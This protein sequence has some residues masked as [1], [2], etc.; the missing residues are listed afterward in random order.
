M[1]KNP[2]SDYGA[3]R[4]SAYDRWVQSEGVPQNKGFY[5][6]SLTELELYPWARKGGKGLFLNLVGTEDTNDAYLCEIAPGTALN[7]DQHLWEELTYILDGRGSTEIWGPDG[8]PMTFEWGPGALFAVPLGARY[9]HHNGSGTKPVRYLAVTSAPLMINLFHDLDFIFNCPYTFA[10]RFG[11]E[12]D[13]F[14]GEGVLHGTRIWETNLVPDAA[15]FPLIPRAERGGD[16]N[17]QLELADGSMAAHISEFPV[18]RYKKAHRHGPGAH[19]VILT[20]SGYSL[21]WPEGNDPERFDWQPGAL[22]V[23]PDMWFHQHFNTGPTP[24]RYLALRWY[25]NKN[26]VFKRYTGDQSMKSGGNQIDFEDQDPRIQAMFDEALAA[27]GVAA[28]A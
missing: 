28:R 16:M 25:S 9:R 22:L 20:G 18:A 4:P 21:M 17:I 15:S 19:V 5:L 6:T 23:P 11:G 14:S 3:H 24:A 13:Y 10:K 12:A 1:Q 2:E 27:N 26:P 8:K 7:P